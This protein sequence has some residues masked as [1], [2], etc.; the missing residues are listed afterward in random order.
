MIGV[1]V[2]TSLPVLSG[3]ANHSDSKKHVKVKPHGRVHENTGRKGKGVVLPAETLALAR[4][5]NSAN[6]TCSQAP[7]DNENT[8]LNSK[9][10]TIVQNCLLRGTKFVDEDFPPTKASL[11]RAAHTRDLSKDST[12]QFLKNVQSITSWQ[13]PENIRTKSKATEWALIQDPRPSDICQGMSYVLMMRIVLQ[14]IFLFGTFF[15]GMC[16][17]TGELGNC[18]FVAALALIAERK[19][20]LVKILV[21]KEIN[22][23]GV[24]VVRLFKDGIWKEVIIDDL[25]PCDSFL[26]LVFS[27]VHL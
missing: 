3:L 5:H 20:L 16:F 14:I 19:D 8:A 15:T 13:R 4:Q 10:Q 21:T 6:I 11:F 9:Y 1:S 24:Y 12:R 18:W 25:L 2:K 17:L 26:R 7:G 27:S 22:S 23:V